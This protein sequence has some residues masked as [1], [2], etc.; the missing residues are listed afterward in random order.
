MS[1]DDTVNMSAENS[2]VD[3]A[4]ENNSAEPEE[5]PTAVPPINPS[6]SRDG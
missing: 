6:E 5:P 3:S 1:Q 4:V 2:A